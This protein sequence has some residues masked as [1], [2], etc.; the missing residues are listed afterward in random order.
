MA[1]ARRLESFMGR[2]SPRSD[3]Q[4]KLIFSLSSIPGTEFGGGFDQSDSVFAGGRRVIW[5]FHEALIFAGAVEEAVRVGESC[6]VDEGEEDLV[7]LEFD[8]AD[9]AADGAE[10]GVVVEVAEDV[11]FD[12]F[13]R[14][15]CGGEDGFAEGA[16]EFAGRRGFGEEMLGEGF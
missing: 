10:K 9:V 7:F 16:D 8:H 12:G 2:G 11:K 5:D 14:G 4:S 13:G 1:A 3:V 15:G 6:A